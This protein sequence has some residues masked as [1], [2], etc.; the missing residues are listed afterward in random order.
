MNS[1]NFKSSAAENMRSFDWTSTRESISYKVGFQTMGLRE[2]FHNQA[3]PGNFI[4]EITMA[5]L[6]CI[7]VLGFRLLVLVLIYKT[8]YQYLKPI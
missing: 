3:F 4:D 1:F 7:L 8:Q 2:T 5:G 6:T